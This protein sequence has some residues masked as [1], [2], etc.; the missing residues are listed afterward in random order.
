M[1]YNDLKKWQILNKGIKMS[2][3]N[4]TDLWY[5]YNPKYYLKIG[6]R[7]KPWFWFPKRSI[8]ETKKLIKLLKDNYIYFKLWNFK[9]GFDI[10]GYLNSKVTYRGL[11]DDIC[12]SSV[13]PIHLSLKINEV[14]SA[15]HEDGYSVDPSPHSGCNI[16]CNSIIES[17]WF[18]NMLYKSRE[19][20]TLLLISKKKDI[21][22]NEIVRYISEFLPSRIYL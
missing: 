13:Q 11:L 9:D 10:G 21:I 20:V 8:H 19:I 4:I 6:G 22:P 16:I 1:I 2:E 15:I 5:L 17:I 12:P 7:P 18:D 3:K 14:D